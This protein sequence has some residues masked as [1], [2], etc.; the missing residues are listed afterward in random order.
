MRFGMGI[1]SS[2]SYDRFTKAVTLDLISY[3]TA[4]KKVMISGL[5][6]DSSKAL[7]LHAC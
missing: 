2:K 3:V 7:S 6:G 4:A 1:V 5:L